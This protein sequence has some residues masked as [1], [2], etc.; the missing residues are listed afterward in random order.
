ME[1]TQ[2]TNSTAIYSGTCAGVLE[3]TTAT[4]FAA[5]GTEKVELTI[6]VRGRADVTCTVTR[7]TITVELAST[8]SNDCP[9]WCT[10]CPRHAR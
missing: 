3:G 10:T 1:K 9:S 6:G 4:I 8:Q 5:S 7:E 2:I